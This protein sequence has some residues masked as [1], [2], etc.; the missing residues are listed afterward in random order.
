MSKGQHPK[1][2]RSGHGL[3]SVGGGKR[4]PPT[5]GGQGGGA[6]PV[7]LF[8]TILIIFKTKIRIIDPNTLKDEGGEFK[9]IRVDQI[10]FTQCGFI[11]QGINESTS[12]LT[13]I[14]AG[15]EDQFAFPF[16]QVESLTMIPAKITQ[17]SLVS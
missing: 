14:K 5:G 13:I 15:T 8:A 7:K 11:L 10:E 16:E 17:T 1:S 3:T 9:V 12:I 4:R 2:R 6:P